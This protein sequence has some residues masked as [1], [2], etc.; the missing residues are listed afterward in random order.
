MRPEKRDSGTKERE[1]PCRALI[2]SQHGPIHLDQ[3]RSLGY[4]KSSISRRVVKGEWEQLHPRVYRSLSFAV[5]PLQSIKAASLA[6]GQGAVASHRCAGFL[7]GLDGF[8]RPL[9]EFSIVSSARPRAKG[10]TVHRIKELP[11][12]DVTVVSSIPTTNASRFLVDVGSLVAEETH[13]L[14]IEDAYRRGLTSPAR[15]EWR[16]T[17]LCTN[18][19]RGCAAI[20]KLMK[21]LGQ[22]PATGSGLEVRV[23]RLI[24]HS[25]LPAPLRQFV[26]AEGGKFVARPDFVYPDQKV[27]VEADS[28]RWH[29][30]RV[31]W[32][33]ELRRRNELAK[34]GWI[35]IHVTNDDLKKR[36]NGIIDDIR[37][38]LRQRGHPAFQY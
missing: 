21:D 4:T 36:P 19:R 2:Q 17:E 31:A 15:L 7:L 13:E 26:I 5:T 22:G 24:R 14:A 8:D 3:A 25:D 1:R 10:I 16:I 6:M 18:G 11:P 9:M 35:I 33:R 28:Q 23:A 12:C 30:S 29:T 27:A 20:R 34:L 37:T 32:Q 38:V